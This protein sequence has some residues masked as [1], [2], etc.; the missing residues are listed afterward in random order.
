MS[1]FRSPQMEILQISDMQWK[2]VNF[3]LLSMHLFMVWNLLIPKP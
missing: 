1:R 3:G 2:Y